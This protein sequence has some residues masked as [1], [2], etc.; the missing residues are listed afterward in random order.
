MAT[1]RMLVFAND[2]VYHLFNRGVERR[3]VFT[4]KRE[5]Q[6][7]LD[8]LWFYRYKEPGMRL[9]KYYALSEEDKETFRAS[10]EKKGTVVSIL[11]YC[12]MP[13]HF[14]LVVKQRE[15]GGIS[16]FVANASDS[17][18][19]Y[20]NTKRKRVG[21][22]F[23]GVF[24]AVHVET[25][26]QLLHLTRYVH[27][28]P[29]SSFLIELEAIETYPWSSLFEYLLSKRETLCDMELVKSLI[30]LSGYKKFVYD[31]VSY[32]QELE[33]VKHLVLEE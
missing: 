27:L 22:L 6:R 11:A 13:N 15:E 4:N 2:Q 25:D 8:A 12:L 23:Q 20:F 14:H 5:Y 31:Q 18:A 26:D 21:P 33:K 17:Y 32:A 3:S 1:N 7:M 16:R 29:V 30:Q 9:S 10:L 19:K 24:K 28:N